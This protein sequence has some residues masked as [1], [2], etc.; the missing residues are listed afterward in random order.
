MSEMLAPTDTETTPFTT[1]CLSELQKQVEDGALGTDKTNEHANR[2]AFEGT[3]VAARLV[4]E[5]NVTKIL[6]PS[7]LNEA[8][9]STGGLGGIEELFTINTEVA[10]RNRGD[11]TEADSPAVITKHPG[12]PRMTKLPVNKGDV[13][14]NLKELGLNTTRGAR[15][16]IVQAHG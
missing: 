14:V 9:L 6:D 16:S 5:S 2:T 12:H 10:L 4:L 7:L 8:E 15:S 11:C 3:T 13:G 1:S